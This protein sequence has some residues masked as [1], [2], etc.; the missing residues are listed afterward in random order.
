[1]NHTTELFIPTC[2]YCGARREVAFA[3]RDRI[4]IHCTG[5]SHKETILFQSGHEPTVRFARGDGRGLGVE[6]IV[7]DYSGNIIPGCVRELV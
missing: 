3:W 6:R 2:S 7:T 1:M 4:G 5:C